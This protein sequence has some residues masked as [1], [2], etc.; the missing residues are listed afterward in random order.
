[1]GWIKNL[2]S[3]FKQPLKNEKYTRWLSP[4]EIDA[5]G[6]YWINSEKSEAVRQKNISHFFDLEVEDLKQIRN[7]AIFALAEKYAELEYYPGSNGYKIQCNRAFLRKIA[8]YN[9]II[10]VINQKLEEKK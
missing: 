2:I 10:K 1:M 5:E 7:M 4:K 8:S 3:F 9:L 6:R